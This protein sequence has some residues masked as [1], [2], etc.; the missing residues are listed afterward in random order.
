MTFLG[1]AGFELRA[2]GLES[3]CSTLE[4]VPSPVLVIV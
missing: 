3:M 4:R 1:S 2:L